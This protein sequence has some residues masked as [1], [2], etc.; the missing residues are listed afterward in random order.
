MS[1]FVED[2]GAVYGS[3]YQIDPDDE[4]VVETELIED[5]DRIVFHEGKGDLRPL[6]FVDGV[7]R[8]EGVLYCLDAATG[9]QTRGIA[10]AYACGAV[11]TGRGRPAKITREYIERLLV[12]GGGVH[13][14][15][16]DVPG[17]WHW[18]IFSIQETHPDKIGQEL[19]VRM[20]KAEGR[21]ADELC[22]EGFLT[23]VDGPLTFVRERD[24]AVVGFVKTHHRRLLDLRHHSRLPELSPGQRTSLFTL[25]KDRYSA[26]LRLTR[27]APISG[28]WSGIVRIEL[29]QAAGLGPA[30]A[31]AD[32]VTSALPLYAGVAHADP[33]APQNLQ[34]V[35][36]LEK[37]LRRRL[38]DRSM[39][40]RAV[41]DAVRRAIARE[42][43]P[44]LAA[45]FSVP[46]S[47]H[48]L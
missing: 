36:A 11:V 46:L 1:I 8:P 28:R 5:G 10:G 24:A 43:D 33:R 6:A 15:L 25:G 3:P 44:E 7:R 4:V 37:L 42:T 30:I 40:Q 38:G 45:P 20:R 41:R 19:Q 26:Y 12:W 32:L 47:M 18:E 17:G 9:V 13:R 35:G 39:A 31:I 27:G 21:L 22:R 34:P 48:S 14:L 2:W 29:P 16:P 23:L